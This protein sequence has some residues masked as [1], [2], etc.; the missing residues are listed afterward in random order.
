MKQCLIENEHFGTPIIRPMWWLQPEDEDAYLI[1]DQ[2]AIGNDIV[3]APVLYQGKTE[4]DIYL[5][6]GWWKDELQQQIIRGGK[7]VRRYQVPVDKVPYF[8]RKPV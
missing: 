3:V 5:P 8:L 4:R 1:D 6:N 7:W 2:F